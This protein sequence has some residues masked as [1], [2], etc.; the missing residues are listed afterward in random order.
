MVLTDINIIL[1]LQSV[2]LYSLISDYSTFGMDVLV[3]TVIICASILRKLTQKVEIYLCNISAEI[4]LENTMVN[5]LFMLSTL[6][7]PS[8]YV[9]Q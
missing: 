4:C 7:E 3:N 8:T 5:F 1:A 2:G 9:L 6:L